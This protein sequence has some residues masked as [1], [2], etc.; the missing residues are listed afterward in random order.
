VVVL[1]LSS[2]LEKPSESS[3]DSSPQKANRVLK[4]CMGTLMPFESQAETPESIH[5]RTAYWLAEELD[6]L[7]V[8]GGSKKH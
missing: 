5:A 1:P 6:S 8:S 7:K 4:N 3:K 2:H